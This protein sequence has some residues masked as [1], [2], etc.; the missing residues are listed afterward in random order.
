MSPRIALLALA[1]TLALG[2]LAAADPPLP[3]PKHCGAHEG[4]G[5]HRIND[6]YQRG[7][8]CE[9]AVKVAESWLGTTKCHGVG[10][11]LVHHS[12][13]SCSNTYY[14]DNPERRAKCGPVGGSVGTEILLYWVIR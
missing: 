11:C 6:I 12:Q 3:S 13:W 4:Y 7:A 9:T 2:G 5:T 8:S 1:G 14:R 10:Y